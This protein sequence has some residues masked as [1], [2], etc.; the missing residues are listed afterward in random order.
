MS[1]VQLSEK[2]MVLAIRLIR[3][4]SGCDIRKKDSLEEV[5]RTVQAIPEEEVDQVVSVANELTIMF[6]EELAKALKEKS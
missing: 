4:I 3:T 5:I 6:Y 1:D 2:H